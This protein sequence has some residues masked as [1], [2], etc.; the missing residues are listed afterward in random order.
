[1][2]GEISQL[3]KETFRKIYQDR[4]SLDRLEGFIEFFTSTRRFGVY[5]VLIY[6]GSRSPMLGLDAF[7]IIQ[8]LAMRV[9]S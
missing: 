7:P 3:R 9:L 1:M 2:D 5:D 6:K 8:Q 4:A